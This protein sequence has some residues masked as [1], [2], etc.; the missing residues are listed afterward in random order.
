[1]F[2]ATNTSCFRHKTYRQ[3][4]LVLSLHLKRCWTRKS[5]KRFCL[6]TGTQMELL[7]CATTTLGHHGQFRFQPHSSS[8][9]N[10]TQEN[11]RCK[12]CRA[13]S[14]MVCQHCA[15]RHV[16][17]NYSAT[18]SVLCWSFSGCL[19]NT[20]RAHILTSP[21]ISLLAYLCLL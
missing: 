2:T 8:E 9:E 21:L 17:L 11:K 12:E 7:R 1:M 10:S 18:K 15:Y 3:M 16:S 13:H 4:A 5:L 14:P 6:L 19:H 20:S